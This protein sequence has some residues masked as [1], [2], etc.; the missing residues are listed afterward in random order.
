MAVVV[1]Y[2]TVAL[3]CPSPMKG[4]VSAEPSRLVTIPGS[5]AFKRLSSFYFRH[6]DSM[7]DYPLIAAGL[8]LRFR[9]HNRPIQTWLSLETHLVVFLSDVLFYEVLLISR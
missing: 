5:V 1:D 9:I 7:R 3:L 8:D 4:E 6:T 2:V